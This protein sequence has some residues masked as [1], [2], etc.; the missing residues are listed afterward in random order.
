L[1]GKVLPSPIHSEDFHEDIYRYTLRETRSYFVV[2][3]GHERWVE[4]DT[5][6]DS[7]NFDTHVIPTSWEQIY[8]IRRVVDASHFWW[9]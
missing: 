1:A 8:E 7:L 6:S 9:L 3:D 5:G 2:Q 4:G